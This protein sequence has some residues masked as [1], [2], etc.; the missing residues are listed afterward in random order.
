VGCR[1]GFRCVVLEEDRW[2]VAV[3]ADSHF[4]GRIGIYALDW[5]PLELLGPR[6]PLPVHPPMQEIGG[7]KNAACEDSNRNSWSLLLCHLHH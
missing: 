6:F 4:D 2:I 7:S 1:L 3:C 5:V